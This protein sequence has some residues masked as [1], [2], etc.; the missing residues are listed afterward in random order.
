MARDSDP[1][2]A[3]VGLFPTGEPDFTLPPAGTEDDDFPVVGG[4]LLFDPSARDLD[5]DG[6]DL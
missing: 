5:P 6:D 3:E 2:D 4:E 1:R